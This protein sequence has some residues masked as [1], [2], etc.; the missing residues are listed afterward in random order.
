MLPF[1]WMKNACLAGVKAALSEPLP[2]GDR[3]VLVRVAVI[4]G[5]Y[6]TTDT[7]EEAVRTAAKLAVRQ[8][9]STATFIRL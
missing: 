3:V 5:S 7:D 9:L 6:H 4:D 1:P 8:A 2:S